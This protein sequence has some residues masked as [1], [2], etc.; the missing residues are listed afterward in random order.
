MVKRFG[1]RFVA[2]V[3][4]SIVLA[5]SVGCLVSG[6][7]STSYSGTNVPKSTFDQIKIGS[8]TIGWVHATLGE[9][10]SRNADGDDEVW[11][12]TYT[13]HTDSSGSVFLISPDHF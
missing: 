1:A 13:E 9:P 12:Y 10:S 3:G 7:S 11:K 8:T 6:H 4:L 5:A 2:I